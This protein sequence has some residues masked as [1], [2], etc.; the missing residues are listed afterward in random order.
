MINELQTNPHNLLGLHKDEKR[1]VIRLWRPGA[2]EA[3][4]KVR[5]K[6]QKAKR[7]DLTSLFEVWVDPNLTY[8]DYSIIHESGLEGHDPYAFLP[9]FSKKDEKLFS[10]G[11]HEKIFDVMGG[12]LIQ[13]QSV[14][15]VK[16]ALWAPCAQSV[17]LIGDFNKWNRE[18]HPMRLMGSSGVWEL[19]I[20]GLKEGE[21]YQFFV[22][23]KQ[24]E[25][26]CKADPYAFQGEIRPNQA[27]IVTCIDRYQWEDEKWMEKRKVIDPLAR[28]LNIYEV[29]VGSWKKPGSN[30]I[31]YRTLAPDLARYCEEM[32]Y[33]HVE[34]MPLM[35]HPLDESWGYQVTGFYAISSRYGTVDDFQFLV[36]YLHQHE[37]GVFLDWVPAHFPGDI[38]GLAQFDGTCLYEHLDPRQGY[39]LDWKTYIF[40]Y[41]RYEVRNFLLGSALFY[42]ENMHIDGLRVDAVSSMV[43]LDYSR[44]K[45][46]WI[47]NEKGGNENLEAIDFLQHLNQLVQK[48][49][50]GALMIAEESHAFPKVTTP[51]EKGGLGFHLKWN[52]GWMHD[53][54]TFFQF[55]SS[56][57]LNKVNILIHEL[58]YYYDEHYLLPISH[59]E[60][61]HEKKS[62]L[63]KMIGNEWEKFANLRLFL[64]YMVCHPGKKLLF[65][66]EEFGPWNEWDVKREL[67]WVLTQLPFHKKL[68]R[69]VQDLNHFYKN[70]P[71]L[72][73]KD[74]SKGGFEWVNKKEVLSYFRHGKQE[75]LLCVHNLSEKFLEQVLIPCGDVP[76]IELLN[77]DS[78]EYGGYGII[79]SSIKGMHLNLAPFSTSILCQNRPI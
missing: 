21:R 31:N 53:T 76:L 10:A 11:C 4:L 7:K 20:P 49:F 64:S 36:D 77:T 59:D 41:G 72:W 54:L 67:P 32:G 26:I 45:G 47:P 24:G 42:L 19:F 62:L 73:E 68:K 16:F 75:T 57:R 65:M 8:T 61:V 30:F 38:H 46:E 6:V 66:G 71:A 43:Y 5:G 78:Q 34:F 60:V 35:G 69:C 1:G 18:S 17:L 70:H 25:G 3:S 15:G 58:I 48:K 79:N 50:P 33:T 14:F 37:I 63:S 52:L 9:T 22:I 55:A 56:D 51:V 28:P 74:F 2:K 23:S 29:H 27:S 40:N 13:H 39:H 44:E 12:R